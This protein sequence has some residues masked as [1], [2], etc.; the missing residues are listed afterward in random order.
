MGNRR[1]SREATDKLKMVKRRENNL[2][3][4]KVERKIKK[5]GTGSKVRN[6]N[7]RNKTETVKEL[8]GESGEL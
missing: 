4:G 3:E 2:K 8:T 6:Q 7:N 5:R 1:H